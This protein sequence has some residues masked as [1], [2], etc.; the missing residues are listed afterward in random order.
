MIR[1]QQK[2]HY[3]NRV[4]V[5][6]QTF[7]LRGVSHP[8]A[9]PFTGSVWFRQQSVA[10]ITRIDGHSIRPNYHVPCYRLFRF[11]THALV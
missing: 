10:G 7:T 2:W 1:I 5:T 4:N 9:V 6:V 8:A 11:A 3:F